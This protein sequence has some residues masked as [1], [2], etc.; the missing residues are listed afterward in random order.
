MT[1]CN[2]EQEMKAFAHSGAHLSAMKLSQSIAKEIK[3]LTIDANE[4]P[5]WNQAIEL[6]NRQG[7]SFKY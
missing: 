6:L 7:K 4:F 5:S 1:L 3:I 2:S